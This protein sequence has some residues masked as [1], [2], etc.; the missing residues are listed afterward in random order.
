MLR[1]IAM[2]CEIINVGDEILSGKTLNTNAHYIC[3]KLLSLNLQTRFNTV[4]RDDK[5]DI[6]NITEL[7]IKRSDIIIY[8]GG[9][10]PTYDDFTKEVVCE[11]LSANLILNNEIL[12]NIKNN[13]ESRGIVMSENN[14][15]QAYIPENCTVLK[16]EKGTAPGFYIEAKGKII[17]LLPGPPKE[18]NNMF[19]KSVIP[20]ISKL[21]STKIR[22]EIIR[23]I[24]IGESK[25]EELIKDTIENYKQ[26]TIATYASK[27]KVDIRITFSSKNEQTIESLFEDIKGELNSTIGDYIYSYEDESLE[28]VVFKKLKQNGFKIGFCESCTGGLISSRFTKIS[29]ASSVLDRSIVTYSNRSKIEEV[30]V[31]KET[32]DLYGAVSEQTAIEMAKGLLEKGDLDISV[33]VTG[34]AGPDGGTKNKPNGLVYICLATKDDVIV[35]KNIY[36]GDRED[37]QNRSSNSAFNLI[38]KYLNKTIQSKIID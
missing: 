21:S 29:G 26:A 27:G 32:L 7:A 12:E 22:S 35:E 9:L 18:M 16:N 2:K 4:I 13:F 17:I 31:S 1:G 19:E 28:E 8:T 3:D 23:T 30:G 6:E 34:I 20:L 33:S 36:L 11:K 38:R 10:G 37:I 14:I 24:D 5:T 15:K 25:L